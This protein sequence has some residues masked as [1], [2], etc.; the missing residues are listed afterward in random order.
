MMQKK[1]FIRNAPKGG[2]F[3][4]VARRLLGLV[5][6]LAG[7]AA[8]YLVC[9]FVFVRNVARELAAAAEYGGELP[10]LNFA[11]GMLD[12]AALLLFA[13]LCFYLVYVAFRKAPMLFYWGAALLF[14]V[15]PLVLL[16]GFYTD[17]TAAAEAL[18]G[19]GPSDRV[20]ALSAFLQGINPGWSLASASA[21]FE[22]AAAVTLFLAVFWFLP[23][24][25]TV[26]RISVYNKLYNLYGD[27]DKPVRE[28]TALEYSIRRRQIWTAF[29]AFLALGVLNVLLLLPLPLALSLVDPGASLSP[30]AYALVLGV[31]A[32]GLLISGVVFFYRLWRVVPRDISK[33]GPVPVVVLLFVPLANFFAWY[34]LTIGAA[35]GMNRAF[36]GL[37]MKGSRLDTVLAILFWAVCFVSGAVFAAWVV[38]AP[39]NGPLFEANECM[40]PL[41]N[42]VAYAVC[43]SLVLYFLAFA[44]FARLSY[45]AC[46]LLGAFG[47]R[48]SG[49]VRAAP[50]SGP[51]SGRP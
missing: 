45:T 11:S 32:A 6:F 16:F 27:E 8:L 20:K 17:L 19:G 28:L 1:Y 18:D 34:K 21:L 25:F 22:Y 9:D 12:V 35:R 38:N 2:G 43:L 3:C 40:K 49:G 33:I 36:E 39:Q 47:V 42:W 5:P 46:R 48:V 29:A 10:A 31:F 37:G 23:L 51:E 13:Y 50:A 7:F 15:Y 14:V 4:G 41:L 44:L 24:G 30:L 26:K